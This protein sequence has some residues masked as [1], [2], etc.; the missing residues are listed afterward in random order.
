MEK[1]LISIVVPVYN[2]EKY[3]K[4]CV[5][6]IVNQT[7]KNLEII[8]VDD[9]SP[10]SCPQLCDKLAQE[11]KRIKVIHKK[12]QGLGMA[13]NSGIEIATG[14]FICFFD[15]DDYIKLETIEKAYES[16][17]K[18]NS[19]IV[20]FGMIKI[21]KNGNVLSEDI[22]NTPQNFYSGKE[23]MEFILPNMIAS[24]PISGK[25]RG[26]NMSSSGRMF[27]MELINK[28]KWRF[29]SERDYISEDFYS[30]L[31][32]YKDVKRISI[33]NEA[34][35]YYCTN[36]MSLT[37]KIDNDRYRKVCIC[38]EGMKNIAEKYNYPI[39]VKES[40]DSQFI[41][42]TIGVMK[43]IINLDERKIKIKEEI[44]E[45]I[46]DKLLQNV[47]KNIN[48]KRESL[49]RKVIIYAMR[50]KYIGLTYVLLKAK[51]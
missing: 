41:G 28:I 23:I 27:S 39:V 29:V 38:Y 22:P 20:M 25:K 4:R 37:H 2:A 47:I 26:F 21:D 24:D 51:G 1:E 8:L 14:K 31:L 3:L 11:D 19:E 18:Y 34:F 32:L 48:M 13:R 40:L 9:G 35:Y 5:E 43:L 7:Y 50:K 46:Q 33:I 10:D 36:E 15:S 6:S 30:L 45:I 44:D 16:A 42:S 49:Q 12:N 17:K